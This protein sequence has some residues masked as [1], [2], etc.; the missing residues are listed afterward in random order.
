MPS[1]YARRRTLPTLTSELCRVFNAKPVVIECLSRHG[2]L[3]IDGYVIRPQHLNRWPDPRKALRGRT[4]RLVSQGN[5]FREA[6][7]YGS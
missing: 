3:S 2:Q 7:L 5:V 1:C 4:A 6:K